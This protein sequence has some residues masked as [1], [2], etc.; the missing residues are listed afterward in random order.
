MV[1]FLEKRNK[2]VEENNKIFN[3]MSKTNQRIQIALDVLEQIKAKRIKASKGEY[4]K[5]N[6][7]KNVPEQFKTTNRF[8]FH[9]EINGDLKK[10]VSNVETCNVCAIGS[11]FLCVVE[12]KNNFEVQHKS[13][14]RNEFELNLHEIKKYIEKFFTNEQLAKIEAAF[15]KE[16]VSYVNIL[17]IENPKDYEKFC[18]KYKSE[19]RLTLIMENLVVNNGKFKPLENKYYIHHSNQKPTTPNFQKTKQE[20]LKKHYS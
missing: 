14:Y 20:F 18:K 10:I 13:I 5:I 11:V 2:Q 4:F 17:K 16:F 3:K 15:E 9:P 1:T 8:S 12:R 6:S 7:T 19:Q